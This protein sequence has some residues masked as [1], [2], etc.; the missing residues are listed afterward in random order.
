MN[1]KFYQLWG[2]LFVSMSTLL[3]GCNFSERNLPLVESNASQNNQ[4]T[5]LTYGNFIFQ[6]QENAVVIPLQIQ[7]DRGWNLSKASPISSRESNDLTVNF[8]FHNLDQNTSNLLLDR[9][10][11]ITQ[12]QQLTPQAQ[13]KSESN[14]GGY[15]GVNAS[16]G[17]V[18]SP[19]DYTGE[20]WLYHIV[21][22][23][24]NQDKT[25]SEQ[26]AIR[27]YISD[28][29]GNNL[30]PITPE[31]SQ[32]KDWFFAENYSQVLLQVRTNLDDNLEFSEQ[33]LIGFY[34][35][36]LE[37]QQQKQITPENTKLRQWYLQ[38]L[39][40]KFIVLE[41]ISDRNQDN[42]FNTN[43]A[44]TLYLYD[45]ATETLY[46]ITPEDSQLQSWQYDEKSNFLLAKI[47]EDSNSDR[48]FDTTDSIQIVKLN[49]DQLS[50]QTPILPESLQQ[51]IQQLY[52]I[53]SP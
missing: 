28:I 17:G 19:Q 51:E 27:G 45:L 48:V 24:T 40:D 9:P 38:R 2:L 6:E 31:N 3:A 13:A 11:I 7:G 25:L 39:N 23:D 10:A 50:R 20:Y 30:T 53:E 33:S 42:E 16:S 22:E 5:Q 14:V 36:D 44:V 8:I 4:S 35:Y 41:I 15:S 29:S 26:D 34:I 32:L 43:D 37:T 52:Q 47:R 18:R 46:P 1:A 49:L 21:E 12:Y